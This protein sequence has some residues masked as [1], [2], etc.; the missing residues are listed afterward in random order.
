MDPGIGKLEPDASDLGLELGLHEVDLKRAQALLNR[1][2]LGA[3]LLEDLLHLVHEGVVLLADV[4]P[5]ALFDLALRHPSLQVVEARALSL[6]DRCDVRPLVVGLVDL[7][8][9]ETFL[10]QLL[11][12]LGDGLGLAALGLHDEPVALL[13]VALVHEQRVDRLA[14]AVDQ[15]DDRLAEGAGLSGPEV[16]HA[17]AVGTREVVHEDDVAKA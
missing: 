13:L 5:R 1:H 3:Q 12:E 11:L 6:E 14:E 17:G 10:V 15:L 8:D 16:E 4:V 2:A 9:L 7:D